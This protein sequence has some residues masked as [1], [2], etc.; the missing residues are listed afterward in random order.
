MDAG[1]E[2]ALVDEE[3]SGGRYGLF[4]LLDA[5]Q[6]ANVTVLRI[7]V[8][9]LLQIDRGVLLTIIRC[10]GI[11]VPVVL[12]IDRE[13]LLNIIR[14][15]GNLGTTW[16]NSEFNAVNSILFLTRNFCKNLRGYFFLT[17]IVYFL[18]N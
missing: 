6:Q 16:R 13:A 11:E 18:C 8:P 3:S 7:E 1:D 12:Q 15:L 5:D 4:T 10:L 9:V 14:S 2:C 17:S